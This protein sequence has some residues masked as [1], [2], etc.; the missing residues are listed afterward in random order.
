MR[1][2]QSLPLAL[3]LVLFSAVL[4]ESATIP[5]SGRLDFD[6]IRKGKDIGD[7][8]FAFSGKPSELKVQ[9]KTDINVRVPVIGISAYSFTQTSTE[10]WQN[11]KAVRLTSK[12][13][14][15]GKP[16]DITL[17][18]IKALPASLWNDDTAK[19]RQ[20]TNTIDGHLMAAKVSDLG[21]E[22]I[23][24][25]GAKIPAHHYRIDGELAREVWYDHEGMLARMVLTADDGSIVTYIRK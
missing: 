21:A 15:D 24:A 1:L 12:T 19:A 6:V 4:A 8:Q 3:G 5:A 7:H 16:H 20:L 10:V 25:A 2:S 18:E 14:D 23:D 17:N 11:G 22:N 9:V 13:N